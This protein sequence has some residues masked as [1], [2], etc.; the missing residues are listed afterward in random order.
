MT[1]L[2]QAR[3]TR[4]LVVL[5]FG[6][7]LAVRLCGV[8]W[9]MHD[10]TEPLELDDIYL[11]FVQAGLSL[12]EDGGRITAVLDEQLQQ[13]QQNDL[14][15][16]RVS[17]YLAVNFDYHL[18]HTAAYKLL[19]NTGLDWRE[20]FW[21]AMLF[22][23]VFMG[24]CFFLLFRSALGPRWAALALLP[25][26]FFDQRG[27]VF[28]FPIAHVYSVACGYLMLACVYSHERR[29]Q[30]W[31]PVCAVLAA[32][33]HPGA[34]IPIAVALAAYALAAWGRPT[35]SWRTFLAT[36]AVLAACALR[37]VANRV[38]SIPH[39]SYFAQVKATFLHAFYFFAQYNTYYTIFENSLD[40]HYAAIHAGHFLLLAFHLAGFLLLSLCMVNFALDGTFGPQDRRTALSV[41]GSTLLA[42]LVSVMLV[43]PATP[44][45]FFLR[46]VDLVLPPWVMLLALTLKRSVEAS[47]RPAGR[48]LLARPVTIGV[49]L[50]CAGLY[51][52]QRVGQALPYLLEK[53]SADN[54]I[55]SAAALD[56]FC[57]S[58]APGGTVYFDSMPILYFALTRGIG[59]VR[60]V[61]SYIF[62]PEEIR[63]F[64]PG[65]D[66]AAFELAK[67]AREKDSANTRSHSQL[68]FITLDSGDSLS[69]SW[70]QESGQLIEIKA[71]A[72]LEGLLAG[73][74]APSGPPARHSDWQELSAPDNTLKLTARARLS[75]SG[76]RLGSG[77]AS[78][79]PWDKGLQ[80][81]VHAKKGR[82][83]HYDFR[84][85]FA[86][87][88]VDVSNYVVVDDSS[89]LILLRRNGQ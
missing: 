46:L 78:L 89:D 64:H 5:A 22:T 50:F 84:I 52:S 51:L 8:L 19:R 66:G 56:S 34:V 83:T 44:A 4:L 33:F 75:I 29:L 53:K 58:T 60:P 86:L 62:T 81:T 6:V 38:P 17:L 41:A 15:D 65:A 37:Y 55:Y 35:W 14:D 63:R 80:A 72:P 59:H 13:A 43:F 12:A 61:A 70:P 49:L 32:L 16:E 21:A 77:Q 82:V 67:V 40:T 76:L 28:W 30:A 47:R 54:V 25:M 71:D 27:T 23:Q 3:R 87:P 9:L 45:M 85:S 31:I 42:A 7:F 74:Q 20:I 10:R 26:V 2:N 88:Y 48:R 57:K 11:N 36:T 18:L 69:L 73:Q 68:G 24:L 1:T 79:W 39:E